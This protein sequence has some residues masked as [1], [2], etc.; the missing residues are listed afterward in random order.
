MWQYFGIQPQ[1]VLYSR[2]VCLL[3]DNGDVAVCLYVVFYHTTKH[4]VLLFRKLYI[5]Q[6]HVDAYI[7]CTCT[8]NFTIYNIIN[9]CEIVGGKKLP[10]SQ[11]YLEENGKLLVSVKN[12]STQVHLCATSIYGTS[13]DLL[14][15]SC[16][17]TCPAYIK[18]LISCIH[19][20]PI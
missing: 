14:L 10:V 11:V 15:S 7:T 2:S 8:F 19:A 12:N 6:L 5:F 20:L 1:K 17:Y 3:L 18:L 16:M 9:V 13:V 4:A